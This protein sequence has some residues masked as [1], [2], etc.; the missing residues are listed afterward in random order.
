MEKRMIY[1][2]LIS[3]KRIIDYYDLLLNEGFNIK[4]FNKKKNVDTY[5]YFLPIIR[6]YLFW[7]FNLKNIT[8]FKEMGNDIKTAAC[9]EYKVNIFEKG[10]SEV[11]CFDTG[12]VFIITSDEKILD[13][14]LRNETKESL[15][16]INIRANRAFDFIE[17]K[18]K[19]E[20]K[21][22]DYCEAHLYAYVLEIYKALYLDKISKEIQD[23]DNFDKI[24]NE[25]VEFTQD[26]Y[27]VQMTDK[28]DSTEKWEKEL[29]IDKKYILVENKFDLLYKNNK[30]NDSHDSRNVFIVLFVVLIIIGIINLSNWLR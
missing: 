3:R 20:D 19:T 25:F 14:L 13:A 16:K 21:S 29:E 27:T 12:I 9:G 26:V 7:T 15:E 30:L 2:V 28:D 10:E 1:P 11:I 17:K 18:K 23:P 24:R 22:I 5:E 6:N 4:I 8:E